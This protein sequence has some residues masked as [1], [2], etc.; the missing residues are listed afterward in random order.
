ML[1]LRLLH[2]ALTLASYRN[3]ARA[4]QALHLTQ[5][6][7]SRS[8][9]GLEARLGEQL[10]NRTP[11]GVEP[12]AFGAL[13]LARGRA[14]LDGANDLEREFKRMRGLEL[15]ELRVGAGAYPAHMSV[16]RA[17]GL[18]ALEHPGL[19]IEVMSD[20]LRTMVGAVLAGKLELAVLEL[21]TVTGETR[22]AT[23]SLPSHAAHFYCRAGHPLLREKAPGIKAIL[24]FPYVG[25]RLPPRVAQDFLELA[26]A[27]AI[28]RDTGDYLPAIKVDSI[29]MAKDIVLA[30]D[31][32]SGAPMSFIAEEV[33]QGRLVPFRARAP[34]MQ[35][36]YGFVQRRGVVLSPAAEAFKAAVRKVEAD[37]A[38]AGF[39]AGGGDATSGM[40][41][42]ARTRSP[43][44]GAR[45]VVTPP[46]E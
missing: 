5:P 29:Q 4:A 31:A 40:R 18:M 10:F 37:I 11:R 46:P 23:E 17:V 33:A 14:L 45:V 2:Q 20:D 36:G 42:P 7:L 26:Q 27:G 15:G 43:Q 1:D 3:Y 21:S 35:T 28:D 12:T 9:A 22:L 25:T 41:A 16:G 24:A 8:I 39:G 44:P 13:L 19:R 32:V 6:A 30:S 34:W 38:A